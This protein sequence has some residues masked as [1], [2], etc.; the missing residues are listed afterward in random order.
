MIS[1][2]ISNYFW[3]LVGYLA[4]P[5]GTFLLF[6]LKANEGLCFLLMV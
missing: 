2:A 3:A 5:V 6:L 1:L 4:N